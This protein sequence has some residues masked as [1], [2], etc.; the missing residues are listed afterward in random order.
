MYCRTTTSLHAD[1]HLAAVVEIIVD[2]ELLGNGFLCLVKVRP[3]SQLACVDLVADVSKVEYKIY[4][5][6]IRVLGIEHVSADIAFGV[7]V[8]GS[9]N[10]FWTSLIS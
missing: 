7:A 2:I 10:M 6:E 1:A 4:H 3:N 9:S 5:E 8:M